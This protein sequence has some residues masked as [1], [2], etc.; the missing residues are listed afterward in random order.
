ME[1]HRIGELGP[2]TAVWVWIVRMGKGRWWPGHVISITVKE[3]FPIVD[4]RFECRG[5]GKNGVDGPA[6]V[7]ISTT[8]MRYLELREP[9]QK[10]EDRPRFVPSALLSR[11]EGS[12][13]AADDPQPLHVVIAGEQTRRVSR[14]SSVK[15]ARPRKGAKVSKA[16]AQGTLDVSEEL[17]RAAWNE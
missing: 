11:P 2:G 17:K 14:T 1:I 12:E 16:N 5:T 4:T 3:P 6:F 7:G 9:S 8:R 10:N 13:V 15:K